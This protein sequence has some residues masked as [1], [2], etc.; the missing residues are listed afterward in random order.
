MSSLSGIN[1]SG[2][3]SGLDSGSIIQKLVALER[4]PIFFL[5]R[6]KKTFSKQKSLFN[7]LQEKLKNLQ[8][9][10]DTLRKASTMISYKAET[11]NEGY[12]TVSASSNATPGSHTIDVSQLATAE[13]RKS[14]GKAD[15]DTTTYGTGLL[16]ITIN[17]T[18]NYVT[19]DSSNNT[20]EGIATAINNKGI[21]VSAQVLNTGDPSNPYTL[22]LKSKN[23]GTSNSFTVET[24]SGVGTLNT[25]ATEINSNVTAATDAKFTFDGIA[26]TRSS[27]S[28]SDVIDGLSITLTGI[29][30]D[31]TAPKDTKITIS[32][33]SSATSEKVKAFV[34]AYNAVLEFIQDQQKVTQVDNAKE[35]EAKTKT[36]PLFGDSSL[37]GIRSTLRNLVGGS[38]STGN[39]SYSLLSQIGI[40]SD[41]DGKLTF[42]QG[43]FDDALAD[44]PTA[45]KNL[46]TDSTS[47]IASVIFNQTEDYNDTVDGLIKIRIDGID[48]KNKAIDEQIRRAEEHVNKYEEEL[49]RRFSNLELII[50]QLNSQGGALN[51]L[52]R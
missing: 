2:L 20:L 9:A 37:R 7:S 38:V 35:G 42:N 34:D 39:E 23:E 21:D 4:R 41:K 47:G 18:P 52:N 44:D 26:M 14:N 43:E 10:A 15:K 3:A 6:K 46:F 13:I 24:D 27:N 50:G 16:K 19:I 36:N 28:F 33:D 32:A 49:R 5:E 1:F 25:L 30:S 12:V 48:R 29:H 40:E 11:D 51:A 22:V 31:T 45:V 8:S 17:G